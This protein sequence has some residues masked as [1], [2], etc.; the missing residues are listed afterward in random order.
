MSETSPRTT[1]HPYQLRARRT[2]VGP[3]TGVDEAESD[4]GSQEVAELNRRYPALRRTV[5][6]VQQGPSNPPRPPDRMPRRHAFQYWTPQTGE[7]VP[8]PPSRRADHTPILRNEAR[9]FTAQAQA[10]PPTGTQRDRALRPDSPKLLPHPQLDRNQTPM[11]RH[12]YPEERLH[13]PATA[14][15]RIVPQPPRVVVDLAAAPQPNVG[16]APHAV[17]SEAAPQFAMG[18][19]LPQGHP[20]NTYW[21]AED[22]AAGAPATTTAPSA[23]RRRRRG[24]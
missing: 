7:T 6:V 9:P 18:W 20:L 16:W 13:E 24:G 1:P 23:R 21:P 12:P 4:A 17:A 2:G 10:I 5:Q 22:W 8:R 19:G 15:Y 11:G 14:Q 3:S